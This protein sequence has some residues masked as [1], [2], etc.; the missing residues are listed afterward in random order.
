MHLVEKY[1]RN[2]VCIRFYT[3]E[4][5]ESDLPL[6]TI[7]PIRFDNRERCT[8]TDDCFGNI[9]IN[10]MSLNKNRSYEWSNEKIYIRVDEK[11]VKK[12][13]QLRDF[14]KASYFSCFRLDLRFIDGSSFV[15]NSI[16]IDTIYPEEPIEV[17]IHD[18]DELYPFL[19]S[20]PVYIF[21]K[22]SDDIDIELKQYK[23]LEAP[24]ASN[25]RK[26]SESMIFPAEYTKLKCIESLKCVNAFKTCGDSYDVCEK[27]LSTQVKNK[28]A[29]QFSTEKEISNLSDC[30]VAEFAKNYNMECGLPC[31]ENIYTVVTSSISDCS[32]L[33]ASEREIF[34]NYPTNQYYHVFEE[35]QLYSFEQ[36]LCECGGL[37]GLFTGSSGISIIEVVV[38]LALLLF[39]KVFFRKKIDV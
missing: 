8:L 11:L 26:S 13:Y 10:N 2:D 31:N 6:L 7:C 20:N 15:S 22:D 24:F 39:Q 27:F 33:E 18:T 36:L 30:L 28:Y 16:T 25:C 34:I 32:W 14:I 38:Y 9:T 29:K 23:R 35:A 1:K 5:S 17:F 12:G 21:G 4:Y 19:Q 37:F 3:K